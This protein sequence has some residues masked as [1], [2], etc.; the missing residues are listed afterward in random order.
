MT[1]PTFR[2]GAVFPQNEIEQDAGTARAF[3]QAIEDMG[4]SHLVAYD[5]VIGAGLTSRPNYEE[6]YS[7]ND[8]FCEPLILFGY[9]AGVVR[10]LSFMS[11]VFILPQRQTVLFAKQAANLDILC[12]GRLR[13]GVGLGW[14]DIEY[15][16]LGVPFEGRASRFEDQIPLLRRL[17]TEQTVTVDTPYHRIS[18]AGLNPL[19]FQRPIPLWLGGNKEA[20]LKRAARIGDGWVPYL[21]A[22][23][24]DRVMS[25]F[26]QSVSAAGRDPAEIGVENILMMGARPDGRSA[27]D[28]EAVAH[29]IER[30]RK[31]GAEGVCV[32]TMRMNFTRSEQHLAMFERVVKL[33]L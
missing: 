3:A 7:V 33:A 21:P 15:E 20:A 25:Q 29:D 23:D 16:A 4:Y 9:L 8:S 5:H 14:N 19:P 6:A 18:D 13:L 17:W 12:E 24:A 2:I 32:S 31:A 28:V 30:W 11:A 26:K 22:D 1:R 10:R 27:L